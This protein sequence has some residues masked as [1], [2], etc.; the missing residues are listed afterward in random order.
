MRKSNVWLSLGVK[1]SGGAFAILVGAIWLRVDRSPADE[2]AARSLVERSYQTAQGGGGEDDTLSQ[3]W[4]QMIQR[5]HGRVLRYRITGTRWS[6]RPHIYAFV[7]DAQRE[8]GNTQE[9]AEARSGWSKRGNV[10]AMDRIQVT[11]VATTP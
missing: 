2:Q 1:L 4:Q 10:L 6:W 3:V 8:Q 7:V 5:K 9:T 11:G